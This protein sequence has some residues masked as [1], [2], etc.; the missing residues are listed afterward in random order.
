MEY[1]QPAGRANG[2][3]FTDARGVFEKIVSQ[4][5]TGWDKVWLAGQGRILGRCCKAP[6]EINVLVMA[7]RF[8]NYF[9][10]K[11]TDIFTAGRVSI[12]EHILPLIPRRRAKNP[13]SILHKSIAGRYRPVSYHIPRRRAKNPASILHKS[14]AGRYRTI[15]YH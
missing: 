7:I 3:I 2:V 13:A 8:A 14:I 4:P 6:V 5:L 1:L 12:I 10:I 15:S 11:S 9:T